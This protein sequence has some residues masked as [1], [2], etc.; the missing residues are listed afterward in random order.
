MADPVPFA[1][2]TGGDRSEQWE[3][4]TDVMQAATGPEQ[5][6]RLRGVPR[7]TLSCSGQETGIAR[8]WL[9]TSLHAYG[10]GDWWV[11]V[12][13]DAL[14]VSSDLSIGSTSVAGDAS[15]L[16]FEA[17]GH[18][19]LIGTQPGACELVS[20]TAADGTG[21]TIS[22]TTQAWPAG[23]LLA[24]AWRSTFAR[25]PA[26]ERF[27]GDA[28]T[29]SVEFLASAGTPSIAAADDLPTYR[30]FPVLEMISDWSSAPTWAALR[31]PQVVDY[32]IAAPT[33]SDLVGQP[34][35]EFGIGYTAVGR[36]EVWALFRLLFALAGR[37]NPVWVQSRGHDLTACA[38]LAASS[39]T[40]DVTA[41]GLVAAGVQPQR[42]DLRIE[43]LDGTVLY[44]R[45]VSVA[46]AGAGVERLTLDTAW[47][48]TVAVGDIVRVCYMTF[49]RQSS[50][51][52]RLDW[53]TRDV[54]SIQIGFVGVADDD[55]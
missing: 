16:R 26:L 52:N 17:G 37:A 50:D 48:S 24:P 46:P 10:S 8:Q 12:V 25:T 29:Y 28:V 40:M 36:A 13:T 39:T 18:A 6:R 53:W 2:T 55:A 44:R 22:A 14:L 4:L 30:G 33:R 32:G 27:T 1:F 31:D 35:A 19:L 9:E 49:C 45:V 42:R 23:T 15:M 11:P 20:V 3:W 47:P 38:G 41:C 34:R 54:V 7:V 21:V 5:T 43:L 51:V